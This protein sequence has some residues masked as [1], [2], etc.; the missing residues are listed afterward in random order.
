MLPRLRCSRLG[1]IPCGWWKLL[2][3]LQLRLLVRYLQVCHFWFRSGATGD[4]DGSFS[5]FWYDYANSASLD[6][7]CSATHHV[8]EDNDEIDGL[9]YTFARVAYFDDNDDACLDEWN[10]MTATA[11]EAGCKEET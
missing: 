5:F 9:F 3:Y 10:G 2:G 8:G 11:I 7:Y 4:Y 6:D 1:D